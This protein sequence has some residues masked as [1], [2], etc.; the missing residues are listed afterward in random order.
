MH[1]MGTIGRSLHIAVALIFGMMNLGHGPIMTFAHAA[2]HQAPSAAAS[3]HDHA[4]FGHDAHGQHHQHGDIDAAISTDTG[5]SA[6]CNAFGCFVLVGAAAV[7]APAQA[8]LPIGK[9]KMPPPPTSAPFFAELVD[10][11]PRHHA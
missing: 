4:A 7:Q 10:P 5:L 11:P 6:P 3:T 8:M 2:Q 9:L 1:A